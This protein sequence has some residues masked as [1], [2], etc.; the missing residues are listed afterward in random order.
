MYAHK[1]THR[2]NIQKPAMC[3]QLPV[4][5]SDLTAQKTEEKSYHLLWSLKQFL[6]ECHNH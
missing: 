4:A 1:D 6:S 2:R 5:L 3:T